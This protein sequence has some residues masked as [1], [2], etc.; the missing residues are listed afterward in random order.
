M[1]DDFM[2]VAEYFYGWLRLTNSMA[3]YGGGLRHY[4]QASKISSGRQT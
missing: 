2:A 3:A 1:A 4:V